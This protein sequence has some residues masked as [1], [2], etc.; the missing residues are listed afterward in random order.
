MTN[1]GMLATTAKPRK[2]A[3]HRTFGLIVNYPVILEYR[4]VWQA[5]VQSA[6]A[7]TYYYFDYQQ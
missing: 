4:R 6:V 5:C 7:T 3:N 2:T 1:N